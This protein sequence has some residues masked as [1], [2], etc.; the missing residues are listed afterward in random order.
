MSHYV[1]TLY[2]L[3]GSEQ[4]IKKA[5]TLVEELNAKIPYDEVFLTFNSKSNQGCPVVECSG[6]NTTFGNVYEALCECG[7]SDVLYIDYVDGGE[8]GSSNFTNYAIM[9]EG[10][11]S[12]LLLIADSEEELFD[13]LKE[14]INVDDKFTE[15]SEKEP[16]DIFELLSEM[17][18]VADSR[19]RFLSCNDE[20]VSSW[21]D[22]DFD[23]LNEDD[24]NA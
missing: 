3:K 22:L 11:T 4:A 2:Y 14:Y 21:E 7:L 12:E 23:N 1:T 13:K 16:T 19:Y 20:Q 17:N 9:K 8:D 6:R 24:E 18:E 15:I 10:N 5:E